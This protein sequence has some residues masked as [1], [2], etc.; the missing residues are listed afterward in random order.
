MS[1]EARLVSRYIYMLGMCFIFLVPAPSASWS[2]RSE[3]LVRVLASCFVPR[4]ASNTAIYSFS[5]FMVDCPRNRTKHAPGCRVASQ[6]HQCFSYILS[7]KFD[8]QLP[9]T[10]EPSSC[11]VLTKFLMRQTR[12]E[13]HLRYLKKAERNTKICVYSVEVVHQSLDEPLAP[14][15]S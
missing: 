9:T 6:P 3:A 5:N 2:Y 4:P 13:A 14:F 8:E 1:S 7:Y 10:R 11:K 12:P 15:E